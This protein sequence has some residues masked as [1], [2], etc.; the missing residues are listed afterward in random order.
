MEGPLHYSFYYAQNVFIPHI[1][2]QVGTIYF[3][4][5]RK[6]SLF[7]ICAEFQPQQI[8]YLIDEEFCT[9]KGANET[10]SYPHHFLDNCQIKSNQ[11]DFL[12]DNC[13]DKNKNKVVM[14]CFCWIT[15]QGFN[16]K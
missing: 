12:S 6:Y 14:Q 7:G 5:P 11:L 1:T 15:V 16:S 3:K 13:I 8:N 4:T 2:Q 10:I 9:G